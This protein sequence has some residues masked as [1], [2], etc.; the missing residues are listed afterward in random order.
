MIVLFS[1]KQ[2][3]TDT[4]QI[5][6]LLGGHIGS[7]LLVRLN[8]APVFIKTLDCLGRTDSKPPKKTVHFLGAS[9]P[10]KQLATQTQ[11]YLFAIATL[12]TLLLF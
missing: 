8:A 6:S 9:A 7:F 11:A 1:N 4:I 3:S 2:S 12:Q 5:T 10:A